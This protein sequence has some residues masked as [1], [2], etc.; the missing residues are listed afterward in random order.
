MKIRMGEVS[1]IV[2]H[3]I[4]GNLKSMRFTTN[5]KGRD[6]R[7]YRPY[8]DFVNFVPGKSL[9]SIDYLSFIPFGYHD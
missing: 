2:L 1:E 8:R 5:L 4:E 9:D 6:F 7:S 3:E